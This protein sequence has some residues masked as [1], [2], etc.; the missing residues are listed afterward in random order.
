MRNLGECICFTFL[1]SIPSGVLISPSENLVWLYSWTLNINRL[2][3]CWKYSTAF[4][5]LP[6]TGKAY[7]NHF[8]NYRHSGGFGYYWFQY[9]PC[10][11]LTWNL[12]LILEAHEVWQN[13]FCWA[14]HLMSFHSWRFCIW[15]QIWYLIALISRNIHQNPY[16]L[17][18]FWRSVSLW[19]HLLLHL[20]RG[21]RR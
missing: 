11:K 12:A 5:I 10:T 8:F 2:L 14:S 17:S 4:W 20:S 9:C 3:W 6:L 1:A 19:K 21:R 13:I 18:T 7:I 16:L 15:V